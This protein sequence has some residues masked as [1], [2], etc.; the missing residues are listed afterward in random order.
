MGGGRNQL[1]AKN[2]VV[3]A[4]RNREYSC[5]PDGLHNF[6]IYVIQLRFEHAEEGIDS[7]ANNKTLSDPAT[8][9]PG[10]PALGGRWRRD[11]ARR[12]GRPGATGRRVRP[13]GDPP[14]AARL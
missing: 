9:F 8:E 7:Q 12:T 3:F 11:P 10:D 1:V 4:L 6:L 5:L 2:L 14:E 13:R